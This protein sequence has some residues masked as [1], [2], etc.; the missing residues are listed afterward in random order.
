MSLSE[1]KKQVAESAKTFLLHS[2][3]D[4]AT[5]AAAAFLCC[6]KAKQKLLH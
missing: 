6:R 3:H 4:G 1:I 5:A 2:V